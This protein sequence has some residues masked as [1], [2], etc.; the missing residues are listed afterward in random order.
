MPA[1]SIPTVLGLIDLDPPSGPDVADDTAGDGPRC[2]ACGTDRGLRA[3]VLRPLTA[4]L[5]PCGQTWTDPTVNPHDL[6]RPT[7]AA[8][9]GATGARWLTSHDPWP[10]DVG[11]P[12]SRAEALLCLTAASRVR[13]PDVVVDL[14]ALS[15]RL[16]SVRRIYYGNIETRPDVSLV[17][18]AW[19]ELAMLTTGAADIDTGSGRADSIIR[20]L[21]ADLTGRALA[22]HALDPFAVD[23]LLVTHGTATALL[24]NLPVGAAPDPAVLTPP[25]YSY[26]VTVKILNVAHG[27]IRAEEARTPETC[28]DCGASTHLAI[29]AV[30]P[31]VLIRCRCSRIWAVP[32]LT[33]RDVIDHHGGEHA[34]WQFDVRLPYGQ[35]LSD[36]AADT[37]PY[38]DSA[39]ANIATLYRH[40]GH[41]PPTTAH[42]AKD[43]F[44]RAVDAYYSDTGTPLGDPN[45]TFVVPVRYAELAAVGALLPHNGHPLEDLLRELLVDLRVRTDHF[46]LGHRE[47]TATVA[48]HCQA[49][50]TALRHGRL[51]PP[52]SADP[53]P[54]PEGGTTP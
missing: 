31:F 6:P 43:P 37:Y 35:P 1:A 7:P 11:P 49:A 16:T 44:D 51:Y 36:T 18:I 45:L 47:A 29:V 22:L 52:P 27:V 15:S 8:D 32:T 24:H 39:V 23:N 5:C 38:I 10:D 50:L 2:P 13:F 20:A 21:A 9:D 28:P 3:I 54:S 25:P 14:A 34:P 33:Y 12:T 26:G 17:P 30:H 46:T 4:L 42:R 53:H 19:R 48:A 41:V 40:N